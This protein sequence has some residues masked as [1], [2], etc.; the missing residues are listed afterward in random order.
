MYP[1]LQLADVTPQVMRSG[2]V[3]TVAGL[4]IQVLVPVNGI[5]RL[6]D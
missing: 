4:A 2:C 3:P 5:K 6:L 1:S